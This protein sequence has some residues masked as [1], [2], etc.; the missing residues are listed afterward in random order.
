MDA[1]PA[2]GAGGLG[3]WLSDDQARADYSSAVPTSWP[4]GQLAPGS[5]PAPTLCWEVAGSLLL[6]LLLFN[7]KNKCFLSHH[8]TGITQ[9]PGEGGKIRGHFKVLIPQN[10]KRTEAHSFTQQVGAEPLLCARR[11][12][13]HG[14]V[15]QRF[16]PP[17][18]PRHAARDRCTGIEFG[19]VIPVWGVHTPWRL[20]GAR[21]QAQCWARRAHGLTHSSR[22]DPRDPTFQL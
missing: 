7:Y 11:C 5:L 17:A 13:G 12:A 14:G 20:W 21:C 9:G 3:G 6:L 19:P 10:G 22:A 1:P 2:G 18:R 15:R 4:G 8:V 16:R